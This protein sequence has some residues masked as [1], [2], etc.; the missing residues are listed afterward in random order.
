M[1]KPSDFTIPELPPFSLEEAGNKLTKAAISLFHLTMTAPGSAPSREQSAAVMLGVREALVA[2][3]QTVAEVTR[4]RNELSTLRD[5]HRPQP[6]ADPEKPGAL[7]AACSVHGSIVAWPCAT[8]SA[9]ERILNHG[10]A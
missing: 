2:G 1:P 8:W 6:H 9:A 4:M 5:G 7:C 3:L 10:K